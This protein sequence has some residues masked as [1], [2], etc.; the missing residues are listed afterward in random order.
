MR[1]V[2]PVANGHFIYLFLYSLLYKYPTGK[3]PF[4]MRLGKYGVSLTDPE[5]TDSETSVP[6]LSESELR[7]YNGR[8]MNLT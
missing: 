3:P 1:I 6:V 5:E 7:G 2:P 4:G 8:P